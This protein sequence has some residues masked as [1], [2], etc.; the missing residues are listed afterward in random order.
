MGAFV[1]AGRAHQVGEVFITADDKPPRGALVCGPR[2]PVADYPRLFAKIGHKYAIEGDDTGDGFFRTP[3]EDAGAG[4]F[5]QATKITTEGAAPPFSLSAFAEQVIDEASVTHNLIDMSVYGAQV[6]LYMGGTTDAASGERSMELIFNGV[7]DTGRNAGKW[8]FPFELSVLMTSVGSGVARA[9]IQDIGSLWTQASTAYADWVTL[10]NG[11]YIEIKASGSP[12]AEHTLE[13][14]H[15]IK[16]TAPTAPSDG[17]ALTARDVTDITATVYPTG[18][19]GTGGLSIPCHIWADLDAGTWGMR[20]DGVE[21]AGGA[22]PASG[23]AWEF[24]AGAYMPENTAGYG[25]VHMCKN[26]S[27]TGIPFLGLVF[28]VRKPGFINHFQP[29]GVSTTTYQVGQRGG[30]DDVTLTVANLP[31]HAHKRNEG[32]DPEQVLHATGTGGYGTA[33]GGSSLDYN[34]NNTGGVVSESLGEPIQIIPRHTDVL[35]CIQY[36]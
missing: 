21:I 31:D 4:F 1:R 3:G 25:T 33:A 34:E 12:G 28:D 7:N 20:I 2:Y 6:Y 17:S 15:L 13:Y 27:L 8:I 18:K 32:G 22:L 23:G 36:R 24:Y 35:Y 29:V 10:N 11:V 9:G 26:A 14:I 16:Q 19:T 30:A 5:R